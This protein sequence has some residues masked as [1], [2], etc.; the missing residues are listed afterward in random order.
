MHDG[1]I[2]VGILL[3]ALPVAERSFMRTWGERKRPHASM[4]TRTLE[5]GYRARC[6]IL[7]GIL[8]SALPVAEIFLS[9]LGVNASARMLACAHVPR[10]V[11]IVHD[12][13]F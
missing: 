12:V 2:L 5:G 4:R 13:P 9:T 10:R 1:S 6:S 11:V 7:V 3:S 8:L